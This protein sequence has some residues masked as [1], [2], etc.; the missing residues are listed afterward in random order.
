MTSILG[1]G[2]KWTTKDMR[3]RYKCHSS[4]ITKSCVFERGVTRLF[5][6]IGHARRAY[7]TSGGP[8]SF[9]SIPHEDTDYQPSSTT[10]CFRSNGTVITDRLISILCILNMY[11]YS[12]S[13]D[14]F[15]WA[16]LVLASDSSFSSVIEDNRSAY[17]ASK[18]SFRLRVC[19]SA[20]WRSRTVVL[21]EWVVH[22]ID[23][24]VA[25]F[26]MI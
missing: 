14:A 10:Q 18:A 21:N 2:S 25:Q 1:W 13:R 11:P 6:R 8:D 26:N 3:T 12:P 24:T 15:F 23:E 4:D 22:N 7:D 9:I 16:T 5:Y 17:S 19:C 20:S